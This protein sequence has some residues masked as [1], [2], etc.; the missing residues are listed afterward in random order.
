MP[1]NDFDTRWNVDSVKAAESQA[2]ALG[3]TLYKE[4]LMTSW[5]TEARDVI[6]SLSEDELAALP[7]EARRSLSAASLQFWQQRLNPKPSDYESDK[8]MQNLIASH[9]SLHGSEDLI[10]DL[11]LATKAQAS[12]RRSSL[13]DCLI[14]Q[15]AHRIVDAYPNNSEDLDKQ[16]SA[17]VDIQANIWRST[18]PEDCSGLPSFRIVTEPAILS[19]DRYLP[20]ADG[21]GLM[22]LGPTP[23]SQP[24]WLDGSPRHQVWLVAHEHLHHIQYHLFK[25]LESGLIQNANLKADMEAASFQNDYNVPGFNED[26]FSSDGRGNPAE[27]LWRAAHIALYLSHRNEAAAFK[28]HD[29]I[30][31]GLDARLG[32]NPRPPQRKQQMAKFFL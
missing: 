8:Y 24:H 32:I 18:V 10:D 15:A 6:C 4:P 19:A 20:Q 21:T 29:A 26:I 2:W 14:A 16:L 13:Y 25:R 1:I 12:L 22:Y 31:E 7:L 5:L 28:L 3:S 23:D 30:I 17:V 27:P 11:N 9:I